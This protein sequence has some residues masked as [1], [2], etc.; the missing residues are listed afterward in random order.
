LGAYFSFFVCFGLT[1][2]LFVYTCAFCSLCGLRRLICGPF[3]FNIEAFFRHTWA[4]LAYVC[5]LFLLRGHYIEVRVFCFFFGRLRV[6]LH[7]R[8][9][10]AK[11]NPLQ[12]NRLQCPIFVPYTDLGTSKSSKKSTADPLFW[13]PFS[14][15][16]S[17]LHHEKNKQSKRKM[18][19]HWGEITTRQFFILTTRDSTRQA[20][21]AS[22]IGKL[23][24]WPTPTMVELNSI[25]DDISFHNFADSNVVQTPRC[26]QRA[27][28][29]AL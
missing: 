15:F 5:I 2:T 13:S 9:T 25:S 18:W 23:L 1:W 24:A 8:G 22:K 11:K 19:T 28:I 6:S 14:F 17:T 29:G 20:L 3:F 4:F 7:G 21:E 10:F 16:I 12:K 26:F 27:M